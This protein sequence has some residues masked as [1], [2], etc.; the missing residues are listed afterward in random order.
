M[1]SLQH[2]IPRAKFLKEVNEKLHQITRLCDYFS[3]EFLE[4]QKSNILRGFQLVYQKDLNFAYLLF[5]QIIES[6]S[7]QDSVFTK[8][9]HNGFVYSK[10]DKKIKVFE[11]FTSKNSSTKTMKS[12]FRYNHRD[13]VFNFNN[14]ESPTQKHIP[15]FT[16]MPLILAYRYKHYLKTINDFVSI[17]HIRNDKCGHGKKGGKANVTNID[18]IELLNFII[19]ILDDD[20]HSDENEIHEYG[21]SKSQ[22][23]SN[24][25]NKNRR[26]RKIKLKERHRLWARIQTYKVCLM[27]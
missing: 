7:L 17:N 26:K 4:N 25:A 8:E 24:S 23:V 9:N 1:S 14:N 6:F 2:V 10:N 11:V 16:K 13:K 3:P 20:N 12:N 21:L 19:Y 22:N 27:S 5:Y 18:L 15:M